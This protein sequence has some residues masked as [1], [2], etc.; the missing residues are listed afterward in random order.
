MTSPSSKHMDHGD[1]I[2]EVV[3]VT[4]RGLQGHLAIGRIVECENT[5]T[6]ATVKLRVVRHEDRGNGW[7]A[8]WGRYPALELVK[9]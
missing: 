5:R 2:L 4:H 8:V 7:V 1:H 6:G 9:T 3:E